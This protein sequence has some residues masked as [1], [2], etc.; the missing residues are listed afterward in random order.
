[1][2]FIILTRYDGKKVYVNPTQICFIS[3]VGNV[4]DNTIIHFSGN[5]ENCI[6]V[7]ESPE[8]ISELCK[9]VTE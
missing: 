8:A 2:R 1:M 4:V 7:L 3:V 9:W 6:Q 5:N